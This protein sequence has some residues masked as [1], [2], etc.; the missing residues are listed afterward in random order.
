LTQVALHALDDGSAG[1]WNAWGRALAQAGDEGGRVR[2]Q[3]KSLFD[4]HGE[5][6]IPS[7]TGRDPR[8]RDAAPAA[9]GSR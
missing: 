4:E 7:F 8:L 6:L 2:V 9:A 3:A 5:G 1:L